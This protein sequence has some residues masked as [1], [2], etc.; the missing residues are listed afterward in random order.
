VAGSEHWLMI[1]GRDGVLQIARDGQRVTTSTCAQ[2]ESNW[3]MAAKGEHY[4]ALRG[5][6]ELVSDRGV[7]ALPS[8]IEGQY[9]VALG[10]DGLIAVGDFTDGR[11]WV[12][13]PGSLRAEPA[14]HRTAQLLSVAASGPFIGFGYVDGAVVVVDT[15]HDQRWELIGHGAAVMYVAIDARRRRVVSAANNELRVWE[16]HA[17]AMSTGG[18]LPCRPFNLT[19]TDDPR[20]FATD[21]S[22]GRARLWTPATGQFHELHQHGDIAFG[23][24]TLRGEVCSGGWDGRVLCTPAAGGKSRAV[25]A[26]G[27]RVKSLIACGDRAL[28]AAIADGKIW[29]LDGTA[30]ALYA[31]RVSPYRLAVDDACTRVASGDYDGSLIVY[32]LVA[33]RIAFQVPRAHAGQ[34]TNLVFHGNDVLTSGTD[35]LVKRWRPGAR[36]LELASATQNAGPIA[37][38]RAIGDGWAA[39]INQQTFAMYS[40]EYPG[41]LRLALGHTIADIAVA[42]DERYVAIADL[43]EVV[44]IDRRRRALATAR[45]LAS[46]LVC[47]RFTTPTTLAA[48]DSASILTL[49]LDALRFVP[50]HT[51]ARSPP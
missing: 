39:S 48:C 33:D 13:R 36:D 35:G 22:D 21:C 8:S 10:D 40:T 28:F 2:N 43:D 20:V 18:A 5:P 46:N 26:A 32:D 44:V 19:A 12:V 27:D 1:C 9:E 38:L 14:A 25:L 29:R 50:L 47:I 3:P 37:K 34:I 49:S 17:P 31:H 51:S 11:T 15:V 7:I 4:V 24:A 42:A 41:G 30:R 23:V 6:S 16:L 45:H